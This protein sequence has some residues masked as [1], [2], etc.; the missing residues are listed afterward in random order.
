MHAQ[1]FVLCTQFGCIL[2][3]VP[4]RSSVKDVIEMTINLNT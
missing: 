4:K 3:G 1:S 2:G